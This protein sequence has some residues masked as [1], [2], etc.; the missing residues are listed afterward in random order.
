MLSACAYNDEWMRMQYGAAP[1]KLKWGVLK[2][3]WKKKTVTNIRSSY[4][5]T[6]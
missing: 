6:F 3:I 4:A 2:A 1:G 5:K